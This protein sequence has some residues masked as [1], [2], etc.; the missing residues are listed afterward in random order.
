MNSPAEIHEIEL[1]ARRSDGS[2]VAAD[3]VLA[4]LDSVRVAA[5]VIDGARLGRP[6]LHTVRM[7][8]TEDELVQRS[9]GLPA[10]LTWQGLVRLL[11][12]RFDTVAVVDDGVVGPD[13]RHHGDDLPVELGELLDEVW[14]LTSAEVSATSV[15]VLRTDPDID[16]D[17][18]SIANRGKA[19]VEVVHVDGFTL[20]RDTISTDPGTV[21][22][23]AARSQLPAVAL[24]RE[25]DARGAVVRM[26]QGR[27]VVTCHVDLEVPA[28]LT[29]VRDPATRA[30]LLGDVRLPACRP[31]PRPGW[32]TRWRPARSRSSGPSPGARCCRRASARSPTTCARSSR[33]TP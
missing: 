8:L 26:R 16:S 28:E 6:G 12:H 25:G 24:R 19:T 4:Y 1:A 7:A 31:G 13:G 29:Q 18:Q 9:D 23:L 27:R 11:A 32:R 14:H 17:A 21:V 30:L 3:E 2:A 20:I 5:G 15:H 33:G 10:T 22:D